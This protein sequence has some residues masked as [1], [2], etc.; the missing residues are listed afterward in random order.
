MRPTNCYRP[1]GVM[2]ISGFFENAPWHLCEHREWSQRLLT[3]QEE[4]PLKARDKFVEAPNFEGRKKC[5]FDAKK[6]RE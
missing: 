3:T 1:H 2:V 6:S 5:F 4:A